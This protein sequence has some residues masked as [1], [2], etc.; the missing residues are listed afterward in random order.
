MLAKIFLLLDV[1][2][3]KRGAF[4]TLHSSTTFQ[5]G[6]T[7][8]QKISNDGCCVMQE[9]LLC[10]WIASQN[11]LRAGYSW[12]CS[13]RPGYFTRLMCCAVLSRLVVSDS[14]QPHGLWPAR[15]LCP[16]GFSRQY[17]RSPLLNLPDSGIKPRSALQVDSLPSE[18]PEMPKS[19]HLFVCFD[20][21]WAFCIE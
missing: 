8:D 12:R 20:I 1:D 5:S 11:S 10:V 15:L 4:L 2:G 16:S 21:C 6:S 13:N 3:K 18:P 17:W 9:T 19:Y 7:L 14:L